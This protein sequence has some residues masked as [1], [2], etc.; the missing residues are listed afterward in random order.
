MSFYLHRAQVQVVSR[1]RQRPSGERVQPFAKPVTGAGT[2]SGSQRV[3]LG[4]LSLS[5]WLG[6]VSDPVLFPQLAGK[7]GLMVWCLSPT[8]STREWRGG[9]K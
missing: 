8:L 4:S 1:R 9:Q 7:I 6:A 2:V 5:R 3:C